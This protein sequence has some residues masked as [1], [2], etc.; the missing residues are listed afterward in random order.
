MCFQN[1]HLWILNWS[2]TC[3]GI[4]LIGQKP[5]LRLYGLH[6]VVKFIC[7]CD[8]AAFY[9]RSYICEYQVM[10]SCSDDVD[11]FTCNL[12]NVILIHKCEDKCKDEETVGLG[13]STNKRIERS[14]HMMKKNTMDLYFM[15][16]I[17][18]NICYWYL[19]VIPYCAQCGEP[20]AEFCV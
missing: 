18:H 19:P 11:F 6:M 20:L 10:S 8:W 12:R 15:P 9:H 1:V 13:G 2:W 5:M 3:D 14:T 16:T 17:P 7:N 4:F